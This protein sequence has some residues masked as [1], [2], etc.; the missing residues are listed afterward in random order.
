MLDDEF[1]EEKVIPNIKRRLTTGVCWE[2]EKN[3]INLRIELEE[4]VHYLDKI[5][6]K[7]ENQNK[8]KK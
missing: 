8:E 3:L 7:V 1:I 6:I 5:G 4:L 2:D